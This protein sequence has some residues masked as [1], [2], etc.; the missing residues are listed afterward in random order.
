MMKAK[1]RPMVI[2]Q[3]VGLGE[4]VLVV[5]MVQ[6][7]GVLEVKVTEVT[8][9]VEMAQAEG[10]MEVEAD[11]TEV[12]LEAEVNHTEGALEVEGTEEA[13]VVE[14]EEGGIK[15]A[16]GVAT[17]LLKI[18][19]L[20]GRMGQ[21]IAVEDGKMMVVEA[22]GTKEVVIGANRI[23]G[24]LEVVEHA[25]KEVVGIAKVQTGTS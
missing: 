4:A 3:L 12:D 9:E 17:I 5:G 19:H 6:T 20:T 13:L 15:M 10:V 8:L 1:V 11:P 18:R 14:A 7:E 22:V 2:G 16:V 21:T 23:A 25:M 24:I